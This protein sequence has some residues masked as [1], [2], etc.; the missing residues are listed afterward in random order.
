MTDLKHDFK[1]KDQIK[2]ST[3][4]VMDMLLKDLKQ[5]ETQNLNN[6]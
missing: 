1:L 6:F 2:D 3:G 4:S 5:V